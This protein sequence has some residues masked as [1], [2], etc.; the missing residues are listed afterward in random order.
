MFELSF[1]SRNWFSLGIRS[2]L[3]SALGF[4]ALG[5]SPPA[6]DGSN[7]GRQAVFD[8]VDQALNNHDCTTAI[9]AIEPLLYSE[10]SDNDVRMKAASAYAC[11]AGIDFFPFINQVL[12]NSGSLIGP[13][14]W[15]KMAEF[16]PSTA[17]SDY[18]MEGALLGLDALSAALLPGALVLPINQ[19]NADTYNPGSVFPSDR[20]GDA[21]IFMVL[22][23]MGG[24]GSIQSRYGEPDP[25]T[26]VKTVPLP[27][28]S[29]TAMD[30]AGCAYAA[31]VIDF[32]DAVGAT[33]NVVTG[34]LSTTLTNLSNTFSEALNEACNVGCQGAVPMVAVPPLLNT[35]TWVTSGCALSACASCP[36]ALRDRS[37]CTAVVTDQSSCAAAGIVNFINASAIGWN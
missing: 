7:L 27:W 12:V 28:T 13:G 26:F 4:F 20:I 16:F 19:I 37:R 11:A 5:C 9:I 36:A 31:S 8:L 3:A 14:F 33:A 10:D 24:I 32:I 21:N 1:G 34:Q 23:A 2:L 17:G 22:M 18:K 15:S 30:D 6:F 35:G 29:A 25:V